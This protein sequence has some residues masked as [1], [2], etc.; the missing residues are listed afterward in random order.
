MKS[1]SANSTRWAAWFALPTSV[2]PG[3]Y[4]VALANGLDPTHFVPL[5]AF[6]SYVGPDAAS[7]AT[8]INVTGAAE[9]ARRQPWKHPAAKVFDVTSY[10]PHGLPGCGGSNAERGA[11]PLDPKTGRAVASSLY[12]A[13]ASVAIAKALAAAGAAGGGTVY[14]PRGTYF[15]NSSYGF[16]VPWGVKLEGE[17]KGL[18]SLIFSET[19]GVSSHSSDRS[20][21]SPFSGATAL[22]RGP[23][24]GS[25]GWAIS[26]LTVYM[27]AFHNTMVGVAPPSHCCRRF[28]TFCGAG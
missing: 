20:P 10:G 17:G 1:D 19:Y 16:D 9:E 21:G 11:C 13:N 28:W 3:E 7:N 15:V 5:G 14:F 18:V 2:E 23:T 27:T 25:G 24:A 22:F 4:Q 6:G 8:T 12:W 26:D